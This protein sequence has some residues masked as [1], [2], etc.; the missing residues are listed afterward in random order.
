MAHI[1]DFKKFKILLENND[2]N[3]LDSNRVFEGSNPGGDDPKSKIAVEIDVAAF[4]GNFNVPSEVFTTTSIANFMESLKRKKIS[5]YFNG[6][7]IT[8]LE[9]ITSSILN[10]YFWA[11][12]WGASEEKRKEKKD[13]FEKYA[14][15]KKSWKYTDQ[16]RFNLMCDWIVGGGK[17]GLA[18]NEM[19]TLE[20]KV[21]EAGRLYTVGFPVAS[22]GPIK[23]IGTK[24]KSSSYVRTL[25]YLNTVN[26]YNFM[27]GHDSGYNLTASGLTDGAYLDFGKKRKGVK[28]YFYVGKKIDISKV[29][30]TETGGDE[31]IVGAKTGGEG[32]MQLSYNNGVSDK[33]KSGVKIDANHP[34]VKAEA[35]KILDL[36]GE[37]DYVDSMTLVSSASPV[38]DNSNQTMELYKKEGK[39]TSGNSDP[40]EGK[41][42]ASNNAKLAY[43]R[44]NILAMALKAALGDRLPGTMDVS[45]KISTDEPGGG[46]HAK[47]TWNKASDPGK[48]FKTP[49]GKVSTGGD[50]STTEGTQAGK[51][52][53]Y[54]LKF[55]RFL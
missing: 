38:W 14:G 41:D 34:L 30:D 6:T 28:P 39:A 22:N 4:P 20:A 42:Y 23:K 25:R 9:E 44:G 54:K 11:S 52:Y 53:A 27:N 31:K 13:N 47:Y 32:A 2:L 49:A 8:N 15:D 3:Y 1:S 17:H 26:L 5:K 7:A 18:W 55:N 12:F 19:E 16:E 43:N 45:W 40:G 51:I 50:K 36:L 24:I 48:V 10:G 37:K 46:K 29:E 33:D 21:S 35:E